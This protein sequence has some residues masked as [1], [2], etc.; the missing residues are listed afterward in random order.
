MPEVI[1]ILSADYEWQVWLDLHSGSKTWKTPFGYAFEHSINNIPALSVQGGWG[2]VSAAASCQWVIDQYHPKLIINLGT[3][4]GLE[5]RIERHEILLV[6]KTFQYDIQ[7]QMSDPEEALR[8]YSSKLD[9][10]WLG[11]TILPQGVIRSNMFSA[12]RDILPSDVIHLIKDHDARAADW[13]SGAIAWVAERNQ[14]PLIILRGVSD[15]VNPH[16]GESYENVNLFQKNTRKIIKI[17]AGQL[18]WW[19]NTYY[20]NRKITCQAG[21]VPPQ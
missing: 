21:D 4:G 7:E 2:K 1:V 19:V 12:D 18:P 15:L 20:R 5:G 9:L 13:E 17:L 11:T 14:T 16:G 3:C 6:E 8:F 10:T